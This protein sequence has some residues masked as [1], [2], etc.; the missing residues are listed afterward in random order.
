METFGAIIL[1]FLII[2]GI[3]FGITFTIGYFITNYTVDFLE[4]GNMLYAISCQDYY[5]I[6]RVV[7]KKYP[8]YI[9][10]DRIDGE[11]FNLVILMKPIDIQGGK[12]KWVKWF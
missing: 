5:D 12:Q 3:I 9:E 8:N 7:D 6:L 11:T 10:I 1:G 4:R 2:M